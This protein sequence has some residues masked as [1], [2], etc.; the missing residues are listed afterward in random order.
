MSWIVLLVGRMGQGQPTAYFNGPTL[1]PSSEFSRS[2]AG[3]VTASREVWER[4]LQW[5]RVEKETLQAAGMD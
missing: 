1:K 4:S 5:G 2:F 3:A